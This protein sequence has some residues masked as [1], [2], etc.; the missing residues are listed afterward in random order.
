MDTFTNELSKTKLAKYL[1]V[2]VLLLAI[3]FGIKILSAL[4]EYRYIGK[5]V[6]PS[7]VISVSGKGEVLAKPDI[8]SFTFSIVESG[9]TAKD[10]QDKATKKGNDTIAVIKSM[11]VEDKDIKTTSYNIYPK[12]EYSPSICNQYSCPPTK[13][14]ITGYEVNQSIEV[15]I[16]QIDK[17]GEAL[18]KI[19]EMNVS[20]ISGIS[21][22]IDDEEKLKAEA[23]ELA[24]KD[25]REK[26][27]K[28]SKDLGVKIKK[29][30]S[31]YE[32]IPYNPSPMYGMGGD[33]K[34]MSVE[35]VRATPEIPVGENKFI[36]NITITYEIE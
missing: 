1:S 27:K 15:K 36:S 18:A 32:D 8:A 19:G 11:G 14:V 12:Y 23:R 13:Q 34:V 29:I 16:R 4:K 3:F 10:A 2:F 17:A 21:F 31:Y 7:S 9:K 6:Y 28:L 33:T 35:A 22:V 30:T 25:A 20:N 24:I 5:G 26:S